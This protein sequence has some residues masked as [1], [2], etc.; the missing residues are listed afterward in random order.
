MANF[1]NSKSG[2]VDKLLILAVVF[3]AIYFMVQERNKDKV[4]NQ[5]CIYN[6][7]HVLDKKTGD[8]V[9]LYDKYDKPIRCEEGKEG[10]K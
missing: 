8:Y 6:I 5:K 10:K 2:V 3:A 9:V 7:T 4:V 1:M